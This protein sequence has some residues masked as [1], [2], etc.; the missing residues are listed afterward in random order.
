VVAG[1]FLPGRLRR[2]LCP[3]QSVPLKSVKTSP[4]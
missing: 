1:R 2:A 3:R 4:I